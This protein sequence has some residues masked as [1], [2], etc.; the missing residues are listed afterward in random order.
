[1]AWEFEYGVREYFISHVFDVVNALFVGL[2]APIQEV[3]SQHMMSYLQRNLSS[4][5]Q[6]LSK[7]YILKYFLVNNFCVFSILF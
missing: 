1:M 5:I 2:R 7:H 3:H 4:I 6:I